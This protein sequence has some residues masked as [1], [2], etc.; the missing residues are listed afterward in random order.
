VRVGD[1][2]RQAEAAQQAEER[3]LRRAIAD[4]G[5][6]RIERLAQEIERKATTSSRRCGMHR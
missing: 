6:D 3:E 4:N 2:Q 1:Q 5:G